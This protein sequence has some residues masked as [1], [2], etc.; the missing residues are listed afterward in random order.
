MEHLIGRYEDR[1]RDLIQLGTLQCVRRQH[2]LV[3]SIR[4]TTR[5]SALITFREGLYH[6]G[7][8]WKIVGSLY[9]GTLNSDLSF[10]PTPL[11][12][13][14]KFSLSPGFRKVLEQKSTGRMAALNTTKERSNKSSI[15]APAQHNQSSRKGK[16][17]WRKNVN[18]EDVEGG[19]DSMRT[20]E[21]V[22]G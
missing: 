2:C 18:V 9:L 1:T 12:L 5:P 8:L 10:R 17:A 21:R 7:S 19:L 14:Y 15:G 16:K 4:H 13:S 20:E 3:Q 11:R 22:A 6:Q